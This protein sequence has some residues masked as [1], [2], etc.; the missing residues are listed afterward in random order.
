[1]MF[2]HHAQVMSRELFEDFTSWLEDKGLRSWGETT[3]TT[4]LE[5]HAQISAHRV[6]KRKVRGRAGDGL[7]R[8]P[9]AYEDVPAV[10]TAWTGMRFRT[11]EDDARD[12]WGAKGTTGS[13]KKPRPQPFTGVDDTPVVAAVKAGRG[14]PDRQECDFSRIAILLRRVHLFRAEYFV[15]RQ[16]GVHRG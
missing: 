13:G 5:G 7:S 11:A 3:F 4:R 8:P 10:Y 16:A 12:V 9:L 15:G 14:A 2:D 1:M 6:E